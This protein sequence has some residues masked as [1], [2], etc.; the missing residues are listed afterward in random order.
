MTLAAAS[1]STPFSVDAAG[2]GALKSSAAPGKPAVDVAG[3]AA[4]P[5]RV[6]RAA[7]TPLVARRLHVRHT[8][9]YR[10]EQPI[11]RSRHRLHLRPCHD[12]IQN[13]A[14]HELTVRTDQRTWS[15]DEGEHEDPF[16]N[17][18]TRFDIDAPYTRL[19]IT[20]ESIVELSDIDPFNLP[21]LRSRPVFP[22]SWMPAEKMMLAAYLTPIEIPDTQ[23]EEVYA[24][25]KTFVDRNKGDVLETL[26][27][28]NLTIFREFAYLPQS[29]TLETTPY[30]VLTTKR[31][32]C[33]DFANLM[34][35]MARMLDIPARYVCGYVYTGNTGDVRST[36]DA[37]HAWVEMYLPNI[38]WKGFDP[39]NGI[40]A[41][42]DHVRLA[43]GRHY[44][45][46]API[47]GTLYS[48]AVERMTVD[49]E[50]RDIT[51]G[52][53][54]IPNPQVPSVTV[55][56]TTPPQPP[57]STPATPAPA[58]PALD[59][60]GPASAAP[61]VGP[62]PEVAV[63]PPPPATPLEQSNPGDAAPSS[64]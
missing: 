40:L 22:I 30:D 46:A 42:A 47:S 1:N 35:C 18:T 52:K 48:S 25:A 41:A 50:V 37:T 56:D 11:T 64:G 21:L 54:V 60:P 12:R 4:Y 39:T 5:G 2:A 31:G 55:S 49:V 16:G 61:S 6:K 19:S 15:P 9:E 33:Q 59:A 58:S 34:I 36:P 51:P 23:L 32:V 13:L 10:Y 14:F 8:T 53:A 24:Y 38:G 29:T 17:A 27:A 26:F 43:V 45:E 63:E 7:A 3:V 57:A 44:R 20:A 62:P 28:L